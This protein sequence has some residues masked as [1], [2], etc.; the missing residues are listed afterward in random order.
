MIPKELSERI[1][2]RI[3]SKLAS[4]KSTEAAIKAGDPGHPNV[5]AK[6]QASVKVWR[7]EAADLRALLTAAQGKEWTSLGPT[8]DRLIEIG[9]RDLSNHI[10]ER[11]DG[12]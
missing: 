8:N 2:A 4:A 10:K 11:A 1:E 5:R 7:E 12:W 9:Y 3:V 6:W